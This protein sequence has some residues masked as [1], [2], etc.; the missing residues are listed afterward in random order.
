MLK[1]TILIGFFVYLTLY[2]VFLFL[3]LHLIPIAWIDEIMGL[4]PSFRLFN[5]QGFNSY[6]WPQEGA[7][8]FFMSYLP[9]QQWLH[10]LHLQVLPF[11][12]YW[13]R[14]PWVIYLVLGSIILLYL[15]RK[16]GF[17]MLFA[18]FLVILLVNDKSIFETTRAVRIEPLIFLLIGLG[19]SAQHKGQH[20]LLCIIA[21]ALLFAHPNVWPMALVF[22]LQAIYTTY[23]VSKFSIKTIMCGFAP[24]IGL[25]L[26]SVFIDFR[27]ADF[28]S[29][30]LHQGADHAVNG[31]ILHRL[32]SHFITRFWPYYTT[33]PWGPFIVYGA[34]VHAIIHLRKQG[35]NTYFAYGIVLTHLV[36][37]VILG[38]FARYNGILLLLSVLY[39]AKPAYT[40]IQQ[41]NARKMG[42][43]ILLIAIISTANVVGRHTM[44]LAQRAER[45]PYPV[46]N[47][48]KQE[49]PQGDTTYLITGS[50]ISYYAMAPNSSAGYFLENIP[51]YKYDFDKY[52]QHL[53]LLDYPLEECEQMVTYEA[54]QSKWSALFKS[55]T[56][57]HLYLQRSKNAQ[58]YAAILKKLDNE[59]RAEVQS[60]K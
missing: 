19:V 28:A 29:Q 41:R 33:Q 60:R 32:H 51:P 48:L 12:I 17:T 14:F 46:I 42:I 37:L 52:E 21:T 4:D 27:Y 36:W 58:S 1:K 38:P 53:L 26:F 50:A 30:F 45:N 23:G 39:I 25:L 59:S 44:A 3:N 13:I 43:I 10:Y 18:L 55:R 6:I 54:K 57:S 40:Y 34:L 35:E 56:Y 2:V 49:L 5:G 15:F 24:I 31:N 16:Q 7:E 9:L 47:W 11:D 22:Y 20:L 8:D